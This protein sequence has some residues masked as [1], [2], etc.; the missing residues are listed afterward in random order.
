[1][2]WRDV[3]ATLD[4]TGRAT[5]ELEIPL[6]LEFPS[7]EG[8]HEG[9]MSTMRLPEDRQHL[10]SMSPAAAARAAA[11]RSV[12]LGWLHLEGPAG[13]ED[14]DA[15]N[16]DGSSATCTAIDDEKVTLRILLPSAGS[17]RLAFQ[18]LLMWV[19]LGS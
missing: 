11:R 6:D 18:A 5:A 4:P 8:R 19:W 16:R 9:V 12:R 10:A 3:V 7:P 1:M 15:M 17:W 2:Q 14:A 13:P